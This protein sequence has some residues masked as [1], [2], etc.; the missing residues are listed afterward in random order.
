MST[1]TQRI[2]DAFA[3]RATDRTPLFEIYSPFHPIYWD[4]CGRTPAT[5]AGLY[6]D[7]LA[8]GIEWEELLYAESSGP[9]APDHM[10]I[11]SMISAGKEALGRDLP[12]TGLSGFTDARFYWL[13]GIPIVHF[14]LGPKD[15]ADGRAHGPDERAPLVEHV[16]G[17]KILALA[18]MDLLG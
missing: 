16:N 5:D 1:P 10:L 18:I 9:T 3:H 4:I 11:Q 17:T 12:V 2:E 6:W 14:G 15:P 8:D 13:R 7:A